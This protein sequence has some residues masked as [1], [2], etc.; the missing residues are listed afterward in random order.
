MIIEFL[1]LIQV[2]LFVI[3]SLDILKFLKYAVLVI[4]LG[5]QFKNLK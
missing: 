2:A 4:I 3:V 1:K 5:K